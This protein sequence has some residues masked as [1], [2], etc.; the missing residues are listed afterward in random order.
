MP[1]EEVAL[2]EHQFGRGASN[3]AFG[4]AMRGIRMARHVGS[5]GHSSRGA[6]FAIGDAG[7]AAAMA[8]WG[9]RIPRSS[10]RPD[11]GR[12]DRVLQIAPRGCAWALSSGSSRGPAAARA[13]R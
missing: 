10:G 11:D 6:M 12:G 1:R 5:M 8:T 4:A 13:R 3:R 2:I 7:G 9:L